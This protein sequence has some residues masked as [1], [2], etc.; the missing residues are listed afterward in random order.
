[1]RRDT[2]NEMLA[3]ALAEASARSTAPRDA[4]R[5][6]LDG[7]FCEQIPVEMI[8]MIEQAGCYVLDDDIL[9]GHRWYSA[10]IPST[11]DDPL[12]AMA[13]AF[14]EQAPDCAVHYVGRQRRV[15]AFGQKL[16]R[17]EADGV[18]FASAKFCE[19]ALYD[20]V[21][22]EFEEKAGLFDAI[23]TQVETFVESV[24]F[25]DDEPDPDA[26]GQASSAAS[27]AAEADGEQP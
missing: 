9:L 7:A 24:L 25:Y 10:D 21:P 3:R 26:P 22:F 20:Y 15:E 6:V 18:I 11:T 14:L 13:G 1:M 4:V 8:E 19:P 23:Q 5:V 12:D 2:H 16:E 27:S 17:A